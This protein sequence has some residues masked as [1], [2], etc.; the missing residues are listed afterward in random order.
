MRN[1]ENA[2]SVV[3]CDLPYRC[4]G[5]CAPHYRRWMKNGDPDP[6][7]PVRVQRPPGWARREIERLL[8]TRVA[9]ECLLWTGLLNLKG[10]GGIFF[11]GKQTFVHRVICRRFHG[12]PPSEKYEVAHSC[13]V[14]DCINPDHLR[15]ATSKENNADR[16]L[17]GTAPLG[18]R[19]ASAKLTDDD[20]R[21]IRRQYRAGTESS[22][23]LA[24]KYGIARTR[25]PLIA[26]GKAWSHVK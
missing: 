6:E 22:R 11:G 1:T 4:S 18:E 23:Q 16:V 24:A 15:W 17:H 3:G 26:K 13:G 8:A 9:G 25:I 19:Q 7:T 10:Y 12:Y 20:V 21:A 14:R 2:C 5:F